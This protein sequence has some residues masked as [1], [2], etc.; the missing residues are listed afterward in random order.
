M[1]EQGRLKDVVNYDPETGIFT[2][3]K[4]RKGCTQGKTVGTLKDNGYLHIGID[5]KKYLLHRLAWLYVHGEFPSNDVDH[6][7]GCRT[8][9]KINNLR[10]VSRSMN[11]EN[12]RFA[13]SH[14]KS[15]GILGVY[16]HNDKFTSRICVRG[17]DVYLGVFDTSDEAKSAYLDAKRSFHQGNTL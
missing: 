11:L 6:I 14:N 13:K 10:S 7:D 16:K 5:G 15:T 9:N 17:K 4:S 8:N 1:V 3:A 2:W 12:M